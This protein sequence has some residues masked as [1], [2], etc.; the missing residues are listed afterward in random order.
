VT[1]RLSISEA[2]RNLSA[3][4]RGLNEQDHIELTRRGEPVA[5]LLSIRAYKRLT[6]PRQSIWEGYEAFRAEFPVENL[7]IQPETF[8]EG[9]DPSAGRKVGF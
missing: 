3:I 1:K 9:R 2:R 4:V 5:V 7:D 8:S 6:T